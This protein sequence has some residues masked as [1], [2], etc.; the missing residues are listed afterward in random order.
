MANV[1]G[2]HLTS[3]ASPIDI[4]F[5]FRADTPPGKDPDTYSQM[6]RSYHKL[7][8]SKP[9]PNGK[10]FDLTDTK[11]G[12][13]LYHQS[14]LGEF[15]LSSDSAVHTFSKWASMAHIIGQFKADEIAAFRSLGYSI[16]GMMIFPGNRINGK[17]T[18]NGARGFHPL[19]KDRIDLTLEYIRRHYIN[20]RSPLSDVLER[21]TDFF[22]LFD[23][24]QGYI[25]FFL[26]QDLVAEDFSGIKFVMPFNNFKT[27][28]VPKDLEAYISYKNLV[29]KFVTERNQRILKAI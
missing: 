8:W 24:F 23:N 4:T 27:P 1:S 3:M 7:L 12:A 11:E 5:D 14:E 26:L 6:L 29:T 2:Q 16:G 25:T 22:S 10:F 9:L 15:F 28:A 13:Y 19:I 17:S 21:Y 18:I 20:E